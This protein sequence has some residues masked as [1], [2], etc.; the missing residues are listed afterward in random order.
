MG[1]FFRRGETLGQQGERLATRY[2]KRHGF[3]ILDRNA[4]FGKYEID[5]IALDGDT[6]AFVEVKTRRTNDPVPPEENVNYHKQQHIIR[7]ARQYIARE[8]NAE[9]YYRF[10]IL[11]IVIPG[12]GKPEYTLFKDA[13]QE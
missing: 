8:N 2:L 13:F 1:R 7:A 5:I 6:T 4:H 12:S 10:D 3:T 9:M 11:A